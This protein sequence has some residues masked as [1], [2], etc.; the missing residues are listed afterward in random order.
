MIAS[1]PS[2]RLAK[3]AGCTPCSSG[4]FMKLHVLHHRGELHA[5]VEVVITVAQHW[6]AE[7]RFPLTK[8]KSREY[9]VTR[10]K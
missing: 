9:A 10:S 7:G 1:L 6:M 8:Q 5:P 3:C 4:D 2:P